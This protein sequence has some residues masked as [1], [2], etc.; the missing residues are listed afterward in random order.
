FV[1]TG[2][3]PLPFRIEVGE[4]LLV[5]RGG[6]VDLLLLL[7]GYLRGLKTHQGGAVDVVQTDILVTGVQCEGCLRNNTVAVLRLNST[8]ERGGAASESN[9]KLQNV[10]DFVRP[11]FAVL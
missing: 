11:K 7:I 6:C 9:G 8:G 1:D 5:C 3:P 2:R 4:R 10:D